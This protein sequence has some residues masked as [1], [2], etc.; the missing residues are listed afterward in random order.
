MYRK[1][2]TLYQVNTR[3]YL[4]KLASKLNRQATL[5][6]IP[7]ER[8]EAWRRAGFDWIY[9]LSVWQTGETG[10]RISRSH[11]DWNREFRET[12][13]DLEE[14]D[15]IGSGFAI[16]GYR[17]CEDIG[18]EESLERFRE[19]LRINGIRM[20][21]D[22]VP[23]HVAHD[24]P[25]VESH[26][27]FFIRGSEEH[28][29]RWPENF[30]RV[31]HP[32]G[33]LI[34]A[35]GRDP[36]F[37]GWPD[38]LQLNYADPLLRDAMTSE[39]L[40]IAA[41]C[42]G[43]RCDMAMLLLPEIFQQTWGFASEPFWP[44]AILVVKK[45]YPDYVF[46]GEVYWDLEWV[47][48]QQ[49]FDF[50]YDK[51]LYDRLVA[52]QATP[53]REH[54]MAGVDYQEKLARF[55]ENHDE[56]RAA[57][58]FSLEEHQAAAILTFLSPGLRFFHQGELS[59]KTKK[60]SP[61]L[62]RGAEEPVNHD[63][64][65]FYAR[66]LKILNKSWFHDGNWQLLYCRPAW[67]GNPT[68]EN[69]IGFQWEFKGRIFLVIVNYAPYRGQCSVIIPREDLPGAVCRLNDRMS[70]AFYDRNCADLIRDGLY[71][72]IPGWAYHVFELIRSTR[73]NL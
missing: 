11:R 72:D 71:L 51:R 12:L 68:H 56:Q 36:Y 4:R 60:I 26:P 70:E 54:L 50:T 58:V 45:M 48:Q 28:L 18:G 57:S 46:M 69:Y 33:E 30:T 59:G 65:N 66:L 61:H 1:N 13:P 23:N 24:H 41:M 64:E 14:H 43:V 40:H 22:F 62:G 53:V 29:A 5:D 47:M 9:L 15:I 67:E 52:R 37:A 55:L 34:L 27:G 3:V 63:V 31:K 39:L 20:M 44:D 19:R 8:I 6:D 42:D 16:R 17:V 21:L 49:G 73:K 2:P 35:Y 32:H 38:T 10:C 25:W 7:D